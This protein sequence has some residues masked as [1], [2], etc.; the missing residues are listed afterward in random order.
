M[1][2]PSRRCHIPVTVDRAGWRL[3]PFQNAVP[4]LIEETAMTLAKETETRP[5]AEKATMKAVVQDRYGSP[6]I[7]HLEETDNPD[8]G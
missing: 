6:D 7:L 3:A 2:L 5:A 8:I 1:T 4:T